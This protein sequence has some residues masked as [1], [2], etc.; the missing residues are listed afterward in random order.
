LRRA[1]VSLT[2]NNLEDFSASGGRVALAASAFRLAKTSWALVFLAIFSDVTAVLLDLLFRE[3][4]A[5]SVPMLPGGCI[6]LLA[7]GGTGQGE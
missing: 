6:F 1:K 3:V 2:F 7:V 4:S 5:G